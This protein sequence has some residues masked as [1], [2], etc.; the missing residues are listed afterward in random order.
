MLALLDPSD[1]RVPVLLRAA[2]LFAAEKCQCLAMTGLLCC[3]SESQVLMR[4]Y[5][6]AL[7][8]L[9]LSLFPAPCVLGGARG[10]GGAGGA[11][12][13]EKRTTQHGGLV[14][15]PGAVLPSGRRRVGL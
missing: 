5:R 11:C 4:A 1:L 15:E 9:I 14:K 12:W 2:A 8:P 13:L 7:Y 10:G 6:R 3:S